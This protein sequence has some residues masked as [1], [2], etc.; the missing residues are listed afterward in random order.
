MAKI[1]RAQIVPPDQ[2]TLFSESAQDI[3][4]QILT[5]GASTVRYGRRWRLGETT[6]DTEDHIIYSRIGFEGDHQTFLWHEERRDFLPAPVPS[7][8]VSPFAVNLYN[9]G[10]VYQTRE[11]DIRISS[12][13]GAL[14]GI[15]RDSSHDQWRVYTFI[16]KVSF[17]DWLP[18]VE[19]V[20]RLRFHIKRPNP[21]WEGRP[22]LENL[23]GRLGDLDTADFEFESADG[24]VTDDE[25]VRE[26]ID[27]V[28]RGYGTGKAVGTRE[29][30][31][32]T[33]ESVLD[34]EHG[35]T[36]E[37]TLPADPTTGDVGRETLREE[38]MGPAKPVAP[39]GG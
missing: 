10:V 29:R 36:E 2:P 7:G 31:G 39:E 21:N 8:Q 24:I 14:Q 18:T 6:F 1:A 34:T 33:V 32:E 20:I 17:Q 12:F 38:L 11:P 27:H 26:L 9:L 3:L 35:E 19:R 15:L 37:R 22:D 16:P 4:V 13:T 5:P 30:N 28:E 23:M 25:L